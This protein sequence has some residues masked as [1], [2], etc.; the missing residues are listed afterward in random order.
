MAT[1][2]TIIEGA[3]R[4]LRVTKR[5]FTSATEDLT[6]GLGA[7]NQLIDSLSAGGIFVPFRT[8][9]TF[10]VAAEQ[11]SYTIGIGGDLNTARPVKIDAITVRRE[12]IDY[13]VNRYG[14]A[15]YNA[16][17][18]KDTSTIPRNYYYEA[19]NPLGTIYFD[20]QPKTDYTLT[21]DS[22]KGLPQF[23]TLGTDLAL[24]EGYERGFKYLLAEELADEYDKP[25]SPTL[26][27]KIHESKDMMLTASMSYKTTYSRVDVA[28]LGGHGRY[29]I[30]KGE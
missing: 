27:K 30:Y 7:L 8:R 24:L 6:E 1:A 12:G 28:L 23:A 20:F 22:L 5:G 2:Q 29:N 19:T 18:L 4:N 15:E 11:S 21:L 25:I 13:T 10:A 3:L 17:S 9:E 14:L 16:L 26:Q